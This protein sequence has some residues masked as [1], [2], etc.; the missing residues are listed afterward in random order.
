MLVLKFGYGS[1]SPLISKLHMNE[2]E[3]AHHINPFVVTEL[4]ACEI[5]SS[6]M[7]SEN[8]LRITVKGLTSRDLLYLYELD[9]IP[10]T[11]WFSEN[12]V[13]MR[14]IFLVLANRPISSYLK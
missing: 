8:V 14:L 11:L 12:H 5:H 7:I 6:S 1:G 10:T 9:A 3:A 4:A 13:L 2:L